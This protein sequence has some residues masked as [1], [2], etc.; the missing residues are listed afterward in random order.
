MKMEK[1]KILLCCKIN[2]VGNYAV[3]VVRAHLHK[4]HDKKCAVKIADHFLAWPLFK[5]A[6][7][8]RVN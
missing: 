4:G 5:W 8:A 3:R 2:A 6:R 7:A 1:N